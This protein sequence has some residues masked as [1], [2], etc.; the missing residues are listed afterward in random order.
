M[1]MAKPF[2][3]TA[4]RNKS[5]THYAIVLPF[6]VTI[7]FKLH[8]YP[9]FPLSCAGSTNENA[10]FAA[11]AVRLAFWTG[12]QTIAASHS[13][14]VQ[15]VI[16]LRPSNIFNAHH[17]ALGRI[18]DLGHVT[19]FVRRRS[20]VSHL[21]RS[22]SVLLDQLVACGTQLQEALGLFVQALALMAVEGG[23]L[24]NAENSFGTEVVLV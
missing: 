1:T 3:R 6:L 11:C 21:A 5:Q 24:Q 10:S 15:L 18:E 13:S 19:R 20:P 4:T 14:A 23:L 8:H 7:K 12:P 16:F 2:T 17:A 9:K 22:H